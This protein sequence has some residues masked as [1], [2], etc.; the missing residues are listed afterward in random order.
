MEKVCSFPHI[1]PLLFIMAFTPACSGQP[2]SNAIKSN[3]PGLAE[4]LK[5]DTPIDEYVVELFE[6]SKGNLWFGTIM[7]G[8]ARYTPSKLLR[9]GEK[10]LTYFSEKDGLP[11]N[12]VVTIAEDK[13]GNMW[14]GTHSGLSKYDGKTFTNYTQKDGLCND[15]VSNILIDRGGNLWVG[16][17]GGVCRYGDGGFSDF[18]IPKPD[19]DLMPYQTTMDWVTEVMEDSQG[20]IWF[21]RDGYGACKYDPSAKLS[22]GGKA[23]THFTKKDGLPSNNVQV[24]REDQQGHIWFGTRVTE[25]DHPDPKKR[26]GDGG[27]CRYDP[28]A[29]FDSAQHKSPETGDK[30]F[31]QFPEWEGLSKNQIYTIYPDKKGHIW[32]GATG[33]GLYRYDPSAS[34]RTGENSFKIYKG[35]NRMDLTYS[36]GVQDMLEDRNGTYWFGFSG[37]L[38]RLEGSSIVHVPQSGPWE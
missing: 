34:L 36:F 30:A 14:F 21:G 26:T 10:T 22:P 3:N 18:P 27:L 33:V 19:V 37:G 6:D 7:S 24:I 20:N 23:F 31:V 28:S 16:T 38:F 15:R 2:N 13:A 32:V 17:W 9:P 8:V 29:H 25:N 12:T 4:M 5:M 1:G 11:G 35:T